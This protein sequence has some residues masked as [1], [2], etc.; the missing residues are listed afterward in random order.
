M[1]TTLIECG[2]NVN[3][4][5]AEVFH[6]PNCPVPHCQAVCIFICSLHVLMLTRSKRRR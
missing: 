4:V 6:V 1:V 5:D 2:A 3:V